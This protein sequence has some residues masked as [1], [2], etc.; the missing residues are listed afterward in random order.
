MLQ[1]EAAGDRAVA[2]DLARALLEA[3]CPLYGLRRGGA[4]LEDVFLALTTEEAEANGTGDRTPGA[5]EEG[6]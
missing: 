4:S 6:S 5:P 2:T 1:V 3:G